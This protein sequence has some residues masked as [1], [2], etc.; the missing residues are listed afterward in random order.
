MLKH[1]SM[2]Q[3]QDLGDIYDL[4][5][6]TGIILSQWR[7]IE[8][9]I[10]LLR[11]AYKCLVKLRPG[12]LRQMPWDSAMPGKTTADVSLKRLPG[13]EAARHTGKRR[14]TLFMDLSA[15]YEHIDYRQLI[16]DARALGFPENLLYLA[17]SVYAGQRII[18]IDTAARSILAGDSWHPFL[19]RS[20]SISPSR[21]C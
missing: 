21:L 18:A 4:V 6:K 16:E 19:P 10:A 8:R 1:L 20:R 12:Y 11:T 17:M 14:S 15:L 13:C 2:K 7:K 5:E 9:P 3:C